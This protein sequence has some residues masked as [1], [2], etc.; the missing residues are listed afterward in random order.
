MQLVPGR[1]ELM[2]DTHPLIFGDTH[3]LHHVYLMF[4]LVNMSLLFTFLSLNYI[5]FSVGY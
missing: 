2:V 1:E 3:T 4:G 5:C